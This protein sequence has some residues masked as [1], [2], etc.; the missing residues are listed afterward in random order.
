MPTQFGFRENYSTTLAITHL[1]GQ[2]LN[3]RDKNNVVGCI[4]LDIAK[5]FD[6][7][8]HNILLCKLEK[9]DIRGIANKLIR[10]YLTNR[11]QTV[12]GTNYF[13]PP[14]A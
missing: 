9:Y 3:E 13:S 1:Y 6:T 11:T 12:S 5:A 4:F 7:I 8:N 2:I 10:S 14:V